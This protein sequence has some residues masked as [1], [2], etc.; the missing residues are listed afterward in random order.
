MGVA[1][2]NHRPL[3]LGATLDRSHIGTHLVDR[4]SCLKAPKLSGRKKGAFLKWGYPQ[5][6]GLY[7]KIPFYRIDIGLI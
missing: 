4:A 3:H 1:L 7:G 5:M 6:D 2:A